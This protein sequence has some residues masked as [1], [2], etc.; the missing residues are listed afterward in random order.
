MTK[1]YVTRNFESR[2]KDRTSN[3]QWIR[4]AI[5]KPGSLREWAKKNHLLTK[6][7]TID[8]KKAGAAASITSTRRVRQVDLARTLRHF[9]RNG[10]PCYH[11]PHCGR[12]R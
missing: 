4:G 1:N 7:G 2:G 10:S 8:L 3:R 12:G 6:R 11:K 5:A 9:H